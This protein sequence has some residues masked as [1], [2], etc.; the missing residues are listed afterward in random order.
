MNYDTSFEGE[1]LERTR[2]CQIWGY[3]SQSFAPHIRSNYR[4]HFS[5][6][7]LANIDAHDSVDLPKLYTLKTLLELNSPYAL[8]MRPVSC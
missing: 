6:W 1:I 7:G 2:H 4:S 3:G 8:Y 5:P